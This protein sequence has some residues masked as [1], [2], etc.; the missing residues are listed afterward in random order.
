MFF[1]FKLALTRV[2]A[3]TAGEGLT[4][5]DRERGL[6]P[7]LWSDWLR[8]QGLALPLWSDWLRERGL[9]LP[10]WSDWLRERGLALPL[11]SD[12]LRERGLALP[13]WSDWLR[14]RGLALPLWSDWLRERGLAPPL[15]ARKTSF[16]MMMVRWM[17]WHCPPD[18]GFEIRAL[19]VWGRAHHLS[20]TEVPHNIE[21]LRVSG[22]E[23]FCH[24]ETWRPEWGLNPRSKPFQ[25]GSFNHWALPSLAVGKMC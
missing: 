17:R 4:R 11:W 10:L 3:V 14:E 8:E 21:S 23:T 1:G 7:L 22:E 24:F 16:S 13:L 15:W 25:A 5:E 19:A 12:W 6:A 9:A 2:Y 20:V 18:T